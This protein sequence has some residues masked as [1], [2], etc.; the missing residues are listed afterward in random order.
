MKNDRS[1]AAGVLHTNQETRNLVAVQEFGRPVV[2]EG[3]Q[4]ELIFFSGSS[5]KSFTPDNVVRR[6]S[7]NFHPP[8]QEIKA[9]TV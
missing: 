1:L 5:T 4:Y 6:P 2:L 9:L 7:L 8:T 3:T